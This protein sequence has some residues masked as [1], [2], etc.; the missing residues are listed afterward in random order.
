MHS[1]RYKWIGW[2]FQRG[3]RPHGIQARTAIAA[4]C[5]AHAGHKSGE[6]D[7]IEAFMN[8]TS[9]SADELIF[10]LRLC[11]QNQAACNGTISTWSAKQFR[12]LLKI[13]SLMTSSPPLLMKCS[14]LRK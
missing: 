9:R 12:Q 14:L 8:R 11:G 13:D 3:V 7:Q 4:R 10:M 6:F 5:I 1:G 2:Q